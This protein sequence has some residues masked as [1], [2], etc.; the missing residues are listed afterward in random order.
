MEP[1]TH[2]LTAYMMSRAGLR[3]WCPAA[4]PVLLVAANV[5][6][7][8]FAAW[9]GGDLALL[10]WH[11]GPTHALFF[12]ALMAALPLPA[13]RFFLRRPFPWGR[14]YAVSLLG[15][16][17]HLALDSTNIYG[18]R[19][20]EPFSSR[21][22]R[23]DIAAVVDLWLLA[24][25]LAFAGWLF[26]SRL[27]SAEI[28]AAAGRGRRVAWAALAFAVLFL[29]GR[30]ALHAR[31]VS[32]LESFLY[33]G[34]APVR[35]A[36]LPRFATPFSWVGLVETRNAYHVLDIDLLSG[37]FDP[38]G[39]R[40][41]YKPEPSPA[42]EAARRTETYRRFS[43]FLQYEMWQVL[44]APEPPGA[45]EVEVMD[46]RFGLPGE[47]RFTARFLV[48]SAGRVLAQSFQYQPPGQRPRFR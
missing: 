23:L 27:V 15:V 39:G 43:R 36:A 21:W 11:R 14:A 34:Q 48:D 38:A 1:A 30:Y 2:T 24:G 20:L 35:V 5:P 44:P 28:G 10:D 29:G 46:M 25:L 37:N 17:S 3:D 32:V 16:L 42:I 9:L 22:V 33:G 8:D 40:T 19:L 31:A 7:T 12:A 18:V 26:L 4:T 6:D 45:T 47:G 13:L 41:F